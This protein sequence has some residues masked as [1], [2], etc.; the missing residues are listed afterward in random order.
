MTTAKIYHNPRCSKS[1]ETLA[2]LNQNVSDIEVV[3]YL[4]TPPSPQE[5]ADILARLAFRPRDVLRRNE[6]LYKSLNLADPTLTDEQLIAII[7]QNP[8][9]LERPIVIYGNKAAIGRPPETILE[10]L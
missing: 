10:I 8:K 9:L 2:L 3:N 1:R 4:E 7:S 6:E 5:L